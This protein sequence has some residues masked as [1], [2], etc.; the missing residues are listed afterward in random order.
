MI[1]AVGRYVLL[2][3]CR[4]A[5]TWPRPARVAVNIS[6]QHLV[7]PSFKADVMGALKSGGLPPSRLEIEITEGIFL[8]KTT[9]SLD[10]VVWLRERGIKVALDDFGTGFS[11]LSYLVSF[12]VDKI[13]IDRSFVTGL[14]ESPQ[15]RAVVDAILL[16]ARTLGIRVV[17]EGV[18]TVEQALALKLRRCDDLQGYL[19]SK[20]QP[21]DE[22]ALIPPVSGG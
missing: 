5:A 16:L 14:L 22:I 6:P 9:A 1:V 19:I 10:A 8:D 4:D 13:K 15:S 3:A 7:H 17:A 18:E 2:E 12:P 20:A 11:S 21:N